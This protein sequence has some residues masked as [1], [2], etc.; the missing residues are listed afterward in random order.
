MALQQAL[1]LLG[2]GDCLPP[3]CHLHSLLSHRRQKANIYITC[4]KMCFNYEAH[5]QNCIRSSIRHTGFGIDERTG[6]D[7]R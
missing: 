7:T 5:S 3:W 2:S 6:A 4:A 1:S